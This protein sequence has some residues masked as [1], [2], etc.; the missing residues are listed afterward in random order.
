MLGIVKKMPIKMLKVKQKPDIGEGK[1]ASTKLKRLL[2]P[3]ESF[4]LNL[5]LKKKMLMKNLKKNR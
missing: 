3:S 2:K 5:R 1:K 4:T